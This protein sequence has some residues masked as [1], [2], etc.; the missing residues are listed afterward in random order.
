MLCGV[1]ARPAGVPQEAAARSQAED[2]C[3]EPVGQ[4]CA[5][6]DTTERMLAA[7]PTSWLA[8]PELKAKLQKIKVRGTEDGGR[9]RG[10]RGV[11]A[12]GHG[13]W[14]GLDVR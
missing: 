10:W 11:G 6:L 8:A 14:C 1:H 5:W 9:G 2:A 4:V 7:E 12:T 13:G 3:T